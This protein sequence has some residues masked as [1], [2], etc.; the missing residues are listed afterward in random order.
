MENIKAALP[1]TFAGAD[2]TAELTKMLELEFEQ[3]E[4]VS[5]G[6]AISG[7]LAAAIRCCACHCCSCHISGLSD[8]VINPAV[9]PALKTDIAAKTLGG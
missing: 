1:T 5:G 6:L 7:G 8:S 2:E 9:N 3:A 4:Q